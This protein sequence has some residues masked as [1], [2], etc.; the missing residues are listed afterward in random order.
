M[1]QWHDHA[2]IIQWHDPAGLAPRLDDRRPDGDV[3]GR[4]ALPQGLCGQ[5][6]PPAHDP[7]SLYSLPLPP[8]DRK[9]CAINPSMCRPPPACGVAVAASNPPLSLSPPPIR[10]HH[11]RCRR[12]PAGADLDAL[13]QAARRSQSPLLCARRRPLPCA[14]L[15]VA[16]A[17]ALWPLPCA[18]VLL[19]PMPAA[20]GAW[21]ELTE[22]SGGSLC[23]RP[24]GHGPP[25]RWCNPA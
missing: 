17:S 24:A 20:S 10:P 12:G 19:C 15:P 9:T 1:I 23:P 8:P 16:S 7:S 14:P 6:L 18:P 11:G 22:V 13:L 21:R 3:R 5:P 4:D 2:T 25:K